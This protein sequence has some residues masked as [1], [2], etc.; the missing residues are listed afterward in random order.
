MGDKI[1]LL[2]PDVVKCIAAGEVVARP[3][4]A[5]KELVENSLDAGAS[6]IKIEL[7][8][9]GKRLIRVI[10]DGDGMTKDDAI[11]CIERHATSKINEASDLFNIQT[12]GFRGEALASIAAISKMKILTR[13]KDEHIGT[14][15]E[16][17]EGKIK[18]VLEA[19]LPIGT[20]I[21]VHN[22]FFNVPARRAFLKSPEVELANCV[23]TAL[24]IALIQTALDLKL[25]HRGRSLLNLEPT[26]SIA[27]RLGLIIGE[28]T[29]DDFVPLDFSQNGMKLSGHA[30]SPKFRFSTSRHYYIYINGRFV[31]DRIL[32]HAIND[33][34]HNFI[35]KDSFGALLINLG[36]ASGLVDVNVHPAKLEVRFSRSGL[37]HEFIYESL[38]Q[39][40]SETAKKELAKSLGK[41]NVQKAVESFELKRLKAR[42]APPP[43]I[44]QPALKLREAE[45]TQEEPELREPGITILG[46]LASTY[47]VCKKGDKLILIDQH[48]S[49]ER[50]QYERLRK[51]TNRK[52]VGQGL[53][54]SKVV[55]LTPKAI[56]IL[57]ENSELLAN[58]GIELEPFGQN[59]V[60]VRTLPIRIK[61]DE[62]EPL[63]S[64]IAD[65]LEQSGSRS[66]LEEISEKVVKLLACKSAIKAGERLDIKE[67][68]ELID[69]LFKLENP[70]SCAHGRPTFVEIDEKFVEKL[71]LRR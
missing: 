69:E 46:Q 20:T 21:E 19:G 39:A 55:E 36:L 68:Q 30:I 29:L 12:L 40:L 57:E 15:I 8:S 45:Q 70:A 59:S 56:A 7:E 33:A 24:Q 35:P 28:T 34:Y 14:V 60:N 50:I 6:R 61:I 37:V 62:I 49:D 23:E 2:S 54:F 9:G 67:M 53:L 64:E 1:R 18:K 66:S 44:I 5:V 13:S 48:A 47:I 4:S 43:R 58:Y 31:R 52:V 16:I 41:T 17:E 27:E 32:I 65:E 25:Y 26:S 71:F 3:S 51:V 63:M 11:L 10:D 38:T 42:T 22:L